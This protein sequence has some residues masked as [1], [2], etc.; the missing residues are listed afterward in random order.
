MHRNEWKWKHNNPKP[1]GHCKSSAKGKIHSIT[2]LG[3]IFLNFS[4]QQASCF[5]NQSC[6]LLMPSVI[7][8]SLSLSVIK[9]WQLHQRSLLCRFLHIPYNS[10]IM[11]ILFIFY[12]STV[13][14]QC[15]ISFRYTAKWFGHIYV[16]VRVCIHIHI[17]IYYQNIFHYRSLQV[18]E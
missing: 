15:Y 3:S 1:M 12:W 4:P 14:L 11:G 18:I 2:G 6:H 13:Y 7:H 8:H 16:C 17:Y 5:P 9:D 10:F